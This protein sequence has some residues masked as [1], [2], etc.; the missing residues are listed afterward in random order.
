MSVRSMPT[1][2]PIR[3]PSAYDRFDSTKRNSWLDGLVS[4]IQKGKRRPSEAGP[5]RSPSPL[6]ESFNDTQALEVPVD[7]TLHRDVFSVAPPVTEEQQDVLVDEDEDEGEEEDR[8]FED[9]MDQIQ[10]D[11][12]NEEDEQGQA[13]SE[14]V[15]EQALINAEEHAFQSHAVGS[16]LEIPRL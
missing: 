6:S 14:N 1:G 16:A 11:Y 2:N 10:E 13:V 9:D 3:L 5:S 4:K 12:V 15:L 7:I 8:L